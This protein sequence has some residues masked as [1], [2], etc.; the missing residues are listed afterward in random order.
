MA[1]RSHVRRDRHCQTK[2]TT[3]ATHPA[4][5]NPTPA[6][7]RPVNVAKDH[8]T[9]SLNAAHGSRVGVAP[10]MSQNTN[11]PFMGQNRQGNN[12]RR[13]GLSRRKPP[14]T[15]CGLAFADGA[16]AAT[17]HFYHFFNLW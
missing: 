12:R 10:D 2:P 13:P 11:D 9:A 1:C 16:T 15:G 3:A 6:S 17:V 8:P 14:A 5:S 4:A 7:S